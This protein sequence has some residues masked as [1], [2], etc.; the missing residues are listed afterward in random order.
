ME[1]GVYASHFL[2]RFL[3]PATPAPLAVGLQGFCVMR[4][5]SDELDGG[6]G[7]R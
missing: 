1:A 2:F 5:L 6:F 4:A 3:L 7:T